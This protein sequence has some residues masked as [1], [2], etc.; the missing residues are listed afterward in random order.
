MYASSKFAVCDQRVYLRKPQFTYGWDWCK[1]VPTCGI[2]GD[3]RLDGIS[4]TV[5]SAFRADTLSVSDDK[6]VLNLFFELDNVSMCT[7]DETTVEYIIE[8]DGEVIYKDTKE[9]YLVGGLNFVNETVVVDNP[10]LWWPNGYGEQSLYTITAKVT[11]RGVVNDMKPRR[12][13][14]RTIKIDHSKLSDGTRN[15]RFVVNGV[16]VFCKGGNWVPADSVYLRIKDETY[17]TL[18]EEAKNSNFTMLRIWGGG[19]YEPDCFYEYCSENGI[20]IMH[21]FMYSCAYYPDNL[22]WFVHEATKEAEYQTKRL[23]HFPCMAVWTGN[24]EIHESY[25]DWF[26]GPLAADRYYGVKIF[27]YIQPKVVATNAPHTPYMPSSPYYG[28][29]ANS[30]YEGDI[31]AWGYFGNDPENKFKFKYELEAFDRIPARF[32][33]EYGFFGALKKSSVEKYLDG[34]ELSFKNPDWIHHGERVDKTNQIIEVIERHMIDVNGLTEDD[35][36]LYSGIMQ[37]CLYADMAEAMRIKPYGSGDL[38]WMYNDC[39]P[40]TGWTTID[41][42]LT[43]KSSFY[44]LKRAFEAVKFIIRPSKNAKEILVTML[45]ETNKDIV[46]TIEYG[47]MTFSGDVVNQQ[48]KQVVLKA[49]TYN[50]ECYE[51]QAGD[52]KTGFY[53]VKSLDNSEVDCATTLR[54]YFRDYNFMLPDMEITSTKQDGSDTVVTIKSANY[55][56]IAYLEV[57]D[58]RIKFSDNYFELVPNIEKTIRIYNCS[59]E[60]ILKALHTDFKG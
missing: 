3:I 50:N 42:Y 46:T 14:I 45:N 26:K 19:L 17:K 8:Y 29:R 5:V 32:S 24:N 7:A 16:N 28:N 12:I 11:C 27:N 48:T 43:R 54:P 10:K 41:Y 56:P 33:S 57:A 30:P 35:Y 25:T 6:A 38:I 18:I 37:G 59:D 15:F 13:G 4:G 49:H 40:E 58:D 60:P 2:G 51:V 39:W 52:L 20:L 36:L 1:P 31:H 23:A 34:G 44:A 47:Y 53:Y 22:D 9:Y 55:V 21:D